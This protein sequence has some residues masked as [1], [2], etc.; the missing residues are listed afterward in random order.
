M[1]GASVV[2][3]TVPGFMLLLMAAFLHMA[4]A[5]DALEHGSVR[6]RRP[7]G[8]G[9]EAHALPARASIENLALTPELKSLNWTIP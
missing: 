5:L 1:A 9:L 6:R 4:R 2:T 7:I 3:S 8:T